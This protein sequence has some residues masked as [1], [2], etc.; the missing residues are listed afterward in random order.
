MAIVLDIIVA[1]AFVLT[2]LALALFVV[3]NRR[4]LR[5]LAEQ[6]GFTDLETGNIEDRLQEPA[7]APGGN[8]RRRAVGHFV[9]ELRA[10]FGKPY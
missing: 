7:H 8:R 3:L 2:P 4:R 9:E 1:V 6:R 5:R 10:W